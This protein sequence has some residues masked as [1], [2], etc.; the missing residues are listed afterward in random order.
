[1]NNLIADAT[2]IT[3]LPFTSASVSN[4]GYDV[5]GAEDPSVTGYRTAW[6]VYTPASDVTVDVDTQLSSSGADTI[7]TVYTSS[8]PPHTFGTLTQLEVNDDN[9]AGF[10]G[11][12][13]LVAGR[14][15]TAGTPYLISVG[16][17]ADE[18]LTYVLRVT[19]HGTI[20]YEP[21]PVVGA[22]LNTLS[23]VPGETLPTGWTT[24]PESVV[25]D[26]SG[27][28]VRLTPPVVP[29]WIIKST[30]GFNFIVGAHITFR[31]T[32]S[33]PG[34]TT[35]GLQLYDG[36]AYTF[37]IGQESVPGPRTIRAMGGTP[38]DYDDRGTP[39]L[40]RIVRNST[41]EWIAYSSVDNVTWVEEGRTTFTST[42]F[43]NT[44]FELSVEAHGTGD[45]GTFLWLVEGDGF[46]LGGGG[47]GGGGG[48]PHVLGPNEYNPELFTV[49]K[50]TG[51]TWTPVDA[52][53]LSYS[54]SYDP[55]DGGTLIVGSETIRFS[56]SGWGTMT[57]VDPLDLIRVRYAGHDIGCGIFTVDNA[58]VTKTVDPEANRYSGNTERVDCQCSAVGTYAAAL[59][60]T[61]TWA[62]KLPSE[63]AITR[64]RRWVTVNGWTG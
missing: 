1:M 2:E 47:G 50:K 24:D 58:T 37:Y 22:D 27:D 40:F 34:P 54:A 41:T 60:T 56:I 29:V 28:G 23:F 20:S 52:A 5:E 51:S 38:S 55:D 43:S 32:M 49:E 44:F 12:W 11:T 33:N 16:S 18:D 36:D 25:T 7:L 45:S 39:E 53:N 15:L 46:G 13:S 35:V 10:G 59:D 63:P 14:V 19:E 26:F 31:M 8:G 4:S 42:R 61:V 64:V 30:G 17:Y 21:I 9:D 3:A 57:L 62:D 6:W 48:H